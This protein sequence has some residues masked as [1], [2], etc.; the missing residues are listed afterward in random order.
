V[1]ILRLRSE[2]V[3][4]ISVVEIVPKGAL[5]TIA[6]KNDAGKSSVLDSIAY[7]LGGTSLVPSEPIRKGETEAKITIDLDDLIVTRRFTREKLHDDACASRPPKD[8]TDH[9]DQVCDCEVVFGETRSTLIVTNQEGARYPSPQ[10]VLDKLLGKLTFDPL[11]FSREL[12]KKQNEILRQLAGIDTTAFDEARK[13][14]ASQRT[15]LK[16]SY[17]IKTAQLL[18]LPTHKGVPDAEVSM[19]TISQEMLKAEQLRKIADEV[20]Q[21]LDAHTELTRV[22]RSAQE[23]ITEQIERFKKD[24]DEASLKLA[25][26]VFEAENLAREHTALSMTVE[27]AIT[28]VPDVAMLRQ[29]ISDI[30]ATNVKVRAN[31]HYATMA[32]DVDALGLDVKAKDTEVKNAET[33]KQLALENAKFPV[34][35]L[36]LGDDGVT[37][38]SGKGPVPFEQASSSEQLRVSVAIG[39]ALNSSLKVLLIRNGNLLDDDKLKLVAEQ[40]EAADAQIWCEYVTSNDEGVSVMLEDGHVVEAAVMNE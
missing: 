14:A 28:A 3:K 9:V 39:L 19:E 34:A 31:V 11:A 7:A 6:G 29:K 27:E 18:A 8:G 22:N 26:L 32:A 4:R 12:P 1:R 17:D 16:R 24:T 2:N 5:I 25:T 20:K 36:G 30:E 15:M 23:R 35:G 37:F 13:V 10:A 33:A 38:D 40:A 21:K